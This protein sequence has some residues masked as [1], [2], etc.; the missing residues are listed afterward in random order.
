MFRTVS[1]ILLVFSLIV[2]QSCVSELDLLS[3]EFNPK[4]VVNCAFNPDEDFTVHLTKSRNILD[5]RDM[6]SAVSDA[7]V[8]IKSSRDQI[9][10][11]LEEFES[12]IYK[13]PG[14]KPVPGFPYTIKVFADGYE[15]V[16]ATSIVPEINSNFEIDTSVLTL[17]GQQIFRVDIN[18]S[19]F[20][21]MGN[22]YMWEMELLQG[23]DRFLSNIKTN[24]LYT[25]QIISADEKQ[26][27]IF[28]KDDQF[29]GQNYSTSF[30]S[31]QALSNPGANTTSEVRLFS[32]SEDLYEYYRTLEIYNSL[33][34]NS[35]TNLSA[36]INVHSNIEN[37]LGIFAGYNVS[38]YQF[39]I[40]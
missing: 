36:P 5:P 30:Y 21:G 12:G 34:T 22:F 25:E 19:D 13:L 39:E 33:R 29:D 10:F 17:E 1:L 2:V 3:P 24:D 31:A 18:I 9:D 26:T 15:S 20:E 35:N 8:I 16:S 23:S 4:L 32:V 6:I 7:K 40:F 14:L 37:G 11:Q 28:L 38:K 27:K